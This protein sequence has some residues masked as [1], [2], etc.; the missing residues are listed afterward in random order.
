MVGHDNLFLVETELFI[1]YLEDYV[2][3]EDIFHF[4]GDE[5]NLTLKNF[6]YKPRSG[7]SKEYGFF[8]V[9]VYITRCIQ[10]L[11]HRRNFT[12]YE[13]VDD[14]NLKRGEGSYR[15][16]KSVHFEEYLPQLL[17]S[18]REGLIMMT[19]LVET[20]YSRCN[21]FLSEIGERPYSENKKFSKLK[22][23]AK[24]AS[25]ID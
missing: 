4:K 21:S 24:C 25:D 15:E 11:N 6:G 5:L 13:F 1:I 12:F 22:D 20:V 3:V 19:T 18:D 14:G 9:G 10:G 17:G 16:E 2:I 23:M 7:H 8:H